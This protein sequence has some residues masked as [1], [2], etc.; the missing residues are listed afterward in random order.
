[1]IERNVN[2][3]HK[4]IA[5]FCRRWQIREFALFGSAVRD[6]FDLGSD[7]DI[8]VTFAPAAEWG[9]LEHVQ[10]EQELL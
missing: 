10:M 2:L 1:M 3:P 5:G 7:L 6:D 9:L 8:L 4:Q